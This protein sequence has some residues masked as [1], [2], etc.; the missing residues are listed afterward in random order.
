M[1]KY[2]LFIIMLTLLI[3]LAGCTASQTEDNSD[4]VQ[5][6]TTDETVI[7]KRDFYEIDLNLYGVDQYRGSQLSAD[8]DWLLIDG[9]SYDSEQDIY[10]SKLL[11]IN[12][13]SGVTKVI[14]EAEW[15]YI[16]DI[17]SNGDL[18]LYT[19]YEGSNATL[20]LYNNGQITALSSN[21]GT[22]SISPDSN[23]IAYVEYEEGL[24]VYDI[25]TGSSQLLSEEKEP[26]YP[27]WFP[28]S[29]QIFYFTDLGQT[30]T[31]GAG[32]LQGLAKI[33]IETKEKVQI[34]DDTGKYRSAKWI[35][36]GEILHVIY[37]WDDAFG[38]AI[39]DLSDNSIL[40]LGE[41]HQYFNGRSTAVNQ[42]KE[43]FYIT[44]SEKGMIYDGTELVDSMDI[45]DGNY[46]NKYMSFS[47][48]GEKMTYLSG[49]IY[50]ENSIGRDIWVA[51]ANGENVRKITN[52]S[53]FYFDPMWIDDETI[54]VVEN[55]EDKFIVKYIDLAE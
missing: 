15:L 7:E 36:P 47:P 30:L 46:S 52:T 37:G 32:Q 13:Y 50:A 16:S 17:S 39:V 1:K 3:A 12:N 40:D 24:F 27:I 34:P 9:M 31:D 35:K 4:I 5:E 22:G 19:K 6:P 44:D 14:D 53:G 33:N 49:D 55:T 51:D 10:L 2:S 11:L 48:D 23:K 45:T 54:V 8:G 42:S 26:W 20:Y 38:N 25:A 18:I 41:D 43:L 29:K 21:F 28:D